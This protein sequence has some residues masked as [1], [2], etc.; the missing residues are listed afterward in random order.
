MNIQWQVTIST[1]SAAASQCSFAFSALGV[2][3]SVEKRVYVAGQPVAKL[4]V[5]SGEQVR[6]LNSSLRVFEVNFASSLAGPSH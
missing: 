4:A 3:A 2:D 6:I 1:A 5:P